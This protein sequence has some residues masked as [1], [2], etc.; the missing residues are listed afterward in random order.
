MLEGAK[1]ALEDGSLWTDEQQEIVE[2]IHN[3]ITENEKLRSFIYDLASKME[4]RP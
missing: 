4:L 2:S 3:V 1:D